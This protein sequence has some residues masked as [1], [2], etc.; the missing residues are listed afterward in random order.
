[1]VTTV[2]EEIMVV[3]VEEEIMVVVV[4]EAAIQV[5]VEEVE[6]VVTVEEEEVEET[7]F[8]VKMHLEVVFKI[9]E[10]SKFYLA[11]KPLFLDIMNTPPG[12]ELEFIFNKLFFQYLFS[13][14]I[15]CV[16]GHPLVMTIIIES[17]CHYGVKTQDISLG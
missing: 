6:G 4:E 3:V 10:H 11:V 1:M 2:V 7:E 13:I 16:I 5:E 9:N 17:I 15:N 12:L 14:S 8:N